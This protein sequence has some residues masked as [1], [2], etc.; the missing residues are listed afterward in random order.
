M[1]LS[2]FFVQNYIP[3]FVQKYIDFYTKHLKIS[4]RKLYTSSQNSTFEPAWHCPSLLHAC[5]LGLWFDLAEGRIIRRCA[6]NYC[7][8]LFYA[9]KPNKRF[10]SEECRNKANR[11]THYYRQ[12]EKAS[13]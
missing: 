1:Y 6:H 10:C 9:D 3:L 11:L 13:S 2:T 8:R 5:Y 12:K 7:E 4:R